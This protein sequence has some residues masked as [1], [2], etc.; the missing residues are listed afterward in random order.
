MTFWTLCSFLISP[1]KIEKDAIVIDNSH[2]SIKDQIDKIS[3]L[4]EEKFSN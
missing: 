1:L 4:I 2:M 3:K